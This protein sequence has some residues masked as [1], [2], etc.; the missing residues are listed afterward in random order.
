M[1]LQVSL[2]L[3]DPRHGDSESYKRTHAITLSTHGGVHCPSALRDL[4]SQPGHGAVDWAAVRRG[5][6]S[7]RARARTL[8]F[9]FANEI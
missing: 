4:V 9:I 2:P 6:E 1:R 7:A 3:C 5:N 8:N